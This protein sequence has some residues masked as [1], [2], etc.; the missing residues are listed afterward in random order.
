LSIWQVQR[1]RTTTTLPN[2]PLA[3]QKRDT[4]P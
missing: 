2:T 1:Q 4:T 3:T